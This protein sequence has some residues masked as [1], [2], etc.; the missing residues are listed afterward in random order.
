MS[1]LITFVYPFVA[2]FVIYAVI[3]WFSNFLKNRL[4][5]RI[6]GTF[7]ISILQA[8]FFLFI[9]MLVALNIYGN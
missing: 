4:I 1:D 6:A 9:A 2:G 8:L 3:F 7:T 5:M